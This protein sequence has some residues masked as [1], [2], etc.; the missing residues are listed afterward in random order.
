MLV[1]VVVVNN[2]KLFKSTKE[3]NIAVIVVVDNGRMVLFPTLQ[4]LNLKSDDRI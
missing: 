4:N 2:V 1:D 3:W